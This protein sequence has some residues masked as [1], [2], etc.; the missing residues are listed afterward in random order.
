L[1]EQF[2]LWKENEKQEMPFYIQKDE[3]GYCSEKFKEEVRAAGNAWINKQAIFSAS[4][5]YSIDHVNMIVNRCNQKNIQKIRNELGHGKAKKEFADDIEPLTIDSEAIKK[6]QQLKIL[7][8]RQRNSIPQVVT[9]AMFIRLDPE[10]RRFINEAWYQEMTEHN[11]K[12]LQKYTETVIE[13]SKTWLGKKGRYQTLDSIFKS[14]KFIFVGY[15]ELQKTYNKFLR[16]EVKKYI[17]KELGGD[18]EDL[19]NSLLPLVNYYVSFLNSTLGYSICHEYRKVK[20]LINCYQKNKNDKDI[21]IQC[22]PFLQAIYDAFIPQ[23]KVNRW[24]N[25]MERNVT[26]HAGLVTILQQFKELGE[27]QKEWIFAW[28][29]TNHKGIELFYPHQSVFMSYSL[30]THYS[31]IIKDLLLALLGKQK[32]VDSVGEVEGNILYDIESITAIENTH[33]GLKFRMDSL[34]HPHPFTTIHECFIGYNSENAEYY[35]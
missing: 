15:A 2:N 11:K 33:Q 34:L 31:N 3:L 30:E 22:I 24:F 6:I 19:C 5:E 27:K 26:S 28:V 16:E 8:E 14:Q 25:T 12:L 10:L 21:F 17:N 18:D 9:E 4:S 20:F 29:N 1:R 7:W 23:Q 35:R 32:T 13:S